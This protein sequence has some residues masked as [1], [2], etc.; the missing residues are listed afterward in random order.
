MPLAH[1]LE[2]RDKKVAR[3][4]VYSDISEAM[5]SVGLYA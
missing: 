2:Q 3:L 1:V 4:T 5:E